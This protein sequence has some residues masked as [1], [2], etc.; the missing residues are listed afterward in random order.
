MDLLRVSVEHQVAVVTAVKACGRV[1]AHD[2]LQQHAP[3][4]LQSSPLEE[5]LSGHYLAARHA[6]EVRRD[7]LNLINA[8]QSLRE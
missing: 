1:T 6:I 5:T 2:A 7:T 4:H 3:R 8:G